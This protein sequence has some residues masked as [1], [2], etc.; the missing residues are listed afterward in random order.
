MKMLFSSLTSKIRWPLK[1]LKYRIETSSRRSDN[2]VSFQDSDLRL[3]MD[4]Y[5]SCLFSFFEP[6]G[7]GMVPVALRAPSTMPAPSAV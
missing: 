6:P 2:G 1:S 7:A 4:C 5:C 3:R